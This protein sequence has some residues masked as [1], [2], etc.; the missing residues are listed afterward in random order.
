MK[1]SEVAAKAAELVGGDRDRTHGSKFEN[2]SNIASLWNGYLSIRKKPAAP[3]NAFDVGALMILLK[4][5][6]TQ[7]G[8]YNADDMID[9]VGYAACTAE[10][11]PLCLSPEIKN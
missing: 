10:V 8:A 3:L 5:A 7:L 2:F 4:I 9:V 1:A 11:E 6:R